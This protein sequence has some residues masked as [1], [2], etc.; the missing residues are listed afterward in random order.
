[1]LY[2]II[3]IIHQRGGT[4]TTATIMAQVIK[5]AM[6]I[7]FRSRNIILYKGLLAVI[8]SHNATPSWGRDHAKYCDQRLSVCLSTCISQE[9]H[10]LFH[11]IPRLPRGLVGLSSIPSALNKPP[12][13]RRSVPLSTA[14]ICH[15]HLLSALHLKFRSF[16]FS[17]FYLP[18]FMAN[19]GLKNIS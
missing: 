17:C 14:I 9:P 8:G 4:G 18:L 16:I 2:C 3:P 7:C 19:K 13:N 15:C 1:M 10:V 5:R 11:Q 12:V 6:A